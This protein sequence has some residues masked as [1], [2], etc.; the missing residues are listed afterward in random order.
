MPIWKIIFD[1]HIKRASRASALRADGL[2]YPIGL[3]LTQPVSPTPW[4]RPQRFHSQ[5]SQL[6]S[7][8]IE[9]Q[10]ER[11]RPMHYK[12]ICTKA[13][14]DRTFFRY[15]LESHFRRTNRDALS[16]KQTLHSYG[17]AP[18]QSQKTLRSATV[19]MIQWTL[20]KAGRKSIVLQCCGVM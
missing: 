13:A 7:D 11:Q 16:S 19:A 14:L 2:H 3:V 15:F 12:V 10:I 5:D 20:G 9:L 8:E 6:Q 4:T 1:S 18:N 17:A